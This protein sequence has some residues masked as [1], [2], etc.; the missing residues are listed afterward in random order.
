M[1]ET[2]RLGRLFLTSPARAA[3][4]CRRAAD[5]RP[6]L[7][8]YLAMTAGYML[9]YWLKP[10]DFPDRNAALPREIQDL[11]FWF[12]VMLWQPPLEA[13]WI[14]C[15]GALVVWFKDG[16][17]PLR[18]CLGVAWAASPF[19]LMVLYANNGL[20][21]PALGAGSLVWASLFY[22][23]ARRQPL[24]DWRALAAFMLGVNAIGVALLLPMTAATLLGLPEV[25]KA[26]QA[27]G[28]LWLLGA[29]T[30]GLRELSGLRLPRAF[31]AMLLSLFFQ[32]AAAFSL[33]LLGVVPKDILKAMMLYG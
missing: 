19:I 18:L 26:A 9:F 21:K 3:G 23:L 16:W 11:G 32:I 17:L 7:S 24:P 2:L 12:K 15:L 5:L 22:P 29:G 4:E 20:S 6:Y 1:R 30:L 33:H 8:L 31:M 14:V 10:F 27:A 25:F 28:A 13:V